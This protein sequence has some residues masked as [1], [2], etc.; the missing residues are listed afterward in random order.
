[1]PKYSLMAH[2]Q[3]GVAFLDSVDGIGALL[4]EPGVGKTGTTLSWIESQA[5]KHGEFRV[6]VVAPLAAADTWVEQP[7]YFMD[8][9]VKARMLRG[10]TASIL[11]KMSNAR[12]W[13]G[14]PDMVTRLDHHGTLAKQVSGNKVTILSMS[15][16]S[17]STWCKPGNRT[18]TVQLL[19][20]VRKYAPHLIVVDESHLIKAH[21]SNISKAMYQ[22]GQ[23]A[24][25]RIILTGTVTPNSPLDVYGQW[26]FLAPWTF[27]DQYNEPWTKNPLR[28]TQAQQRLIKPWPWGRFRDRYAETFHP[29]GSPAGAKQ[30]KGMSSLT[31]Q[32]L[33]DRVAERSH[34]VLKKDALNLPPVTDVDIHVTLSPKEQAAYDGMA[35]ELAAQMANGELVEAKNALSKIMKLRQIHAGFLKDSETGVV[36]K[37]GNSLVR[38]V[39]DVV[40]TT[41]IGKQR[42]VV[43]AY[44]QSE[45][46]ALSKALATR[47]TTV[48]VV[49]GKTPAAER[50]AIRKRFGDVS[51]N[52]GRMVLVA[53]ASTMSLSVNELV[54]AQDAVYA[55]PTQLRAD[56]V[57][58]RDR[59]DRNGQKLPVTFWNVFAPGLIAEIIRDNH[60]NKGSME[61]ALLNHVRSY[62]RPSRRA[63]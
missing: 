7:Q 23:L 30:V 22:L 32:E 28:M 17:I 8:S 29:K 54:T 31:E 58:S 43:F 51:A 11:N 59:L 52:P 5:D 34:V 42:V 3:Q 13:V 50:I 63:S 39:T 19:R 16:G 14:V 20:A 27:S 61:K 56:W 60:L 41:L 38:T 1:M 62:V 44:F 2:Q 36:H 53:Q 18:R 49:T 10:S 26:R 35:V 40:N 24:P 55:S 12:S 46:E 33:H 37:I 45:C 48:E 25:H 4:Y 15:T 9:P 47:G 6:L 21:N 57:Q